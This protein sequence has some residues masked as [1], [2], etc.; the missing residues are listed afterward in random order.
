M[1]VTIDFAYGPVIKRGSYEYFAGQEVELPPTAKIISVEWESYGQTDS[2]VRLKV[3]YSR[4][5]YETHHATIDNS[6][7][8]QHARAAEKFRERR[9]AERKIIAAE[10]LQ[11]FREK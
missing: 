1:K 9:E 8:E 2:E 4:L 10:A 5:G 11:I 3:A 6:Y 7:N